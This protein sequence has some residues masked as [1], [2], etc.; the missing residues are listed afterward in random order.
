[1]SQLSVLRVV[2]G[3]PVRP[4]VGGLLYSSSEE[5]PLEHL[6]LRR[7]SEGPTVASHPP[8][9]PLPTARSGP[10]CEAVLVFIFDAGRPNNPNKSDVLAPVSRMNKRT[11]S[12]RYRF[13]PV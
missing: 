13:L 11:A 7:R 4:H 1:M 3:E 5:F 12:S 6:T 9:C 2:P 10:M 8:T